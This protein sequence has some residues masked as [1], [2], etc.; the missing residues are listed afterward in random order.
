MAESNSH[1]FFDNAL[2]AAGSALVLTGIAVLFFAL[3][4][5]ACLSASLLLDYGNFAPA[6]RNPWQPFSLQM[7][8][9]LVLPVL[10]WAAAAWRVPL[11]QRAGAM[12][13]AFFGAFFLL[14]LLLFLCIGAF[15]KLGIQ[16][17]FLGYLL[18]VALVVLGPFCLWFA[19]GIFHV[20]LPFDPAPLAENV[21]KPRA[22]APFVLCTII[23]VG[24]FYFIMQNMDPGPVQQFRLFAGLPTADDGLEGAVFWAYFINMFFLF[25]SL[26]KGSKRYRGLFV[27]FLLAGPLFFLL[28]AI[29]WYYT[30]W[31]WA[32]GALIL[33]I[34]ATCYFLFSASIRAW[35]K[36]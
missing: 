17:I 29:P 5:Y 11:K 35:Q 36:P 25:A 30:P 13:H 19:Y 32:I 23:T 24:F 16:P 2:H 20:F 6:V 3:F 9:F 34:L 28:P 33:L 4:W 31:L 26:T 21:A 27:A 15:H 1:G 8:F 10:C 22:L 7:F 12:S 14:V 18:D